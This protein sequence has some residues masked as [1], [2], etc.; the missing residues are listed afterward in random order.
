MQTL[1]GLRWLR[2]G[3]ALLQQKRYLTTCKGRLYMIY[4]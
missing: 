1:G 2:N 4:K 3:F